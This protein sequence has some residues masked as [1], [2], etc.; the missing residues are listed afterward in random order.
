MILLISAKDPTLDST[1]DYRFGR[2]PWL[3]RYDTD[4]S[5]WQAIENPGASQSG[6]AGV[7]AAQF[8]IDQKANTVISGDF[9]PNAVSALQAAKIE[10]HLFTDDVTTVQQAIDCF[11]QEKL[12]TFH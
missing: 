5:Q 8:V 10:M 12:P 3:I 11:K 2:S 1:V 4:S 6:G 9:G 7:A